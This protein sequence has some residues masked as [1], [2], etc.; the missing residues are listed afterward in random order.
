MKKTMATMLAIACLRRMIMPPI[1]VMIKPAS[2][3]CNLRCRYCFYHSLAKS[4]EVE[5]YGIMNIEL[6]ELIV[7]K[8]L[9]FADGY[10]TF[11]FQGGEPTLAGLDFYKNLVLFEKKYNTKNVRI[12]NALQTNGVLV[13]EEWARFLSDNNFLVGL[14]LDGTKDV[15]DLN[16]MDATGEGS[17]KRVM[18]TVSLFNKHRVEYNI[19]CVVNNNTAKHIIKIYE[20]FRKNNFKY[21]QFI[22]CLDPLGETPGGHEFSLTADR[23]TNFLKTSFDLWYEDAMKGDGISI[24]YFD[25]LVSM[26]M[27]YRPEACGMAGQCLCQ[28]VIEADGGVYPCDFYVTGEWFLGNIR[29]MGFYELKHCEK[30]RK[31]EDVSK[32]IDAKC[33]GCKWLNLC[34]GGC[35]RNREPFIDGRPAL[36]Y[37][38]ES[39]NE[40]FEYAYGRL[41]HLAT[42]YSAR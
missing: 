10:C 23:F 15:H 22:P 19:L 7:R 24:R 36:N 25:N 33:K 30:G 39:Y 3:S 6:L 31:F 16:R 5:S 32:H 26:L 9:E 42:I 27:G 17:F 40:F 18:N 12:N 8:T 20:F 41:R 2:S 35:R 38:C 28:F 29:D 37:Y 14:S 4:R 21:I 11:A 13:D 34:R 1:S